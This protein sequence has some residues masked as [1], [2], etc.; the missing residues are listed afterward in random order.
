MFRACY[1]PYEFERQGFALERGPYLADFYLPQQ[2]AWVEVKGLPPNLREE[3]LCQCLA[4][5]TRQPVTI[6][7]G[8]PSWGTVVL[9]FT[10]DGD[11]QLTTLAEFLMRWVSLQT[12]AKAIEAARSARFE[13]GETPKV[14]SLRIIH[15]R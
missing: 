7:W 5:E 6:A 13:F 3:D 10:P 1:W 2:G 14:S 15:S 12:I 11:R 9:L 8:Q 4:T